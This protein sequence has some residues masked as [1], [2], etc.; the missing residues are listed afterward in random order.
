MHS[1]LGVGLKMYLLLC[2]NGFWLRGELLPRPE[3]LA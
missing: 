3:A 1:F 2:L